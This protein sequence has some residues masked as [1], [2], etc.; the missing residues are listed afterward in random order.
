MDPTHELFATLANQPEQLADRLGIEL[1]QVGRGRVVGTLPVSGNRQPY[2]MLHGGASVVLAE[3]LG[4]IAAAVH[5][6]GQRVAVGVDISATHHRAA[7]DGLITGV[8]TALHEGSRVASYEIVLTDEQDRRVCT[9][10][11]TCA[12]LTRPPGS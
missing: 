11:L 10:R 1:T 7:R 4:S 2:G 5:A 12:L 3:T 9:A 6:G 8:C